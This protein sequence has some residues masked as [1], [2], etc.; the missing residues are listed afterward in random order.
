VQTIVAAGYPAARVIGAMEVG[1][2][3]IRVIV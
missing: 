3:R 1:P 2:P